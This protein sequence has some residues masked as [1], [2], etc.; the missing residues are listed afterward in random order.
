M[1]QCLDAQ[2]YNCIYLT[3]NSIKEFL[4]EV[5]INLEE[6]SDYYIFKD[7]EELIKISCKS[8]NQVFTYFYNH[9]YVFTRDIDEPLCYTDQDFKYY[10][11][12][13]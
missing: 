8:I 6:D 4:K 10:F 3:K 12:L 9:W 1:Q 13:I 7:T 11:T 2:K 5:K